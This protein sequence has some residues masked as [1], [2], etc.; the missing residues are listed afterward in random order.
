MRWFCA[1]VLCAWAAAFGATL[2]DGEIEALLRRIEV[3]ASRESAW[4]RIETLRH[5]AGLIEPAAPDRAKALR[6]SAKSL[7]ETLASTQPQALTGA[8]R[9]LEEAAAAGDREAIE[10]AAEAF[11]AAVERSEESPDDYAWFAAMR[12]RLDIVKG[13]DNPSVRAREALAEL[14]ELVRTD[15][16]FTLAALDGQPVRLRPA[17]GGVTV[18][19]FWATWCAPCVE[20]MRALDRIRRREGTRIVAITDEPAGAVRPFLD[21]YPVAFDVL[22]DPSRAAFQRFGIDALP[23]LLI[24]DRTGR[25]R[26]RAGRVTEEEVLRLVRLAESPL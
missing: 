11:I 13:G 15:F 8:R 5:A 21:A 1:A 7:E 10:R 3:L 12:R 14:A 4:P 2:Y 23:A 25:L 18:V 6:E 26:A 9:P 19:S 24:V 16:D 20:E 22:L 17:D